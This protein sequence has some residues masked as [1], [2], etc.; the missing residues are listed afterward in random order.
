[1]LGMLLALGFLVGVPLQ[2]AGAEDVPWWTPFGL[3]GSA[4]L[5]GFLL[6]FVLVRTVGVA[7]GGLL[8]GSLIGTVVALFNG[9][10]A[11][12][13]GYLLTALVAYL[14]GQLQSVRADAAGIAH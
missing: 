13:V 1:M 10:P 4:A 12:A 7:A 3:A 2:A 6:G 9:A 5:V 11:A 8:A 14:L